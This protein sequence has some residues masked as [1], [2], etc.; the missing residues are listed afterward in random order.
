MLVRPGYSRVDHDVFKVRSIA[1]GGEQPV[2]HAAFGPA[3]KAHEH[4]VRLAKKLVADRAT[5]IRIGRAREPLR[6]RVRCQFRSDPGLPPYPVSA[7]PTVPIDRLV[8]TRE[9][10]TFN[11]PIRKRA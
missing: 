8:E 4:A 6:R 7:E 1:H 2:P 3:R 5:A 11:A 10:P 9:P